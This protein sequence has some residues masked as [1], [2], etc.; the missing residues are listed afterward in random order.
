MMGEAVSKH[1]EGVKSYDTQI[2]QRI[3]SCCMFFF[4]EKTLCSV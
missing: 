3:M 4:K 2:D 1:T